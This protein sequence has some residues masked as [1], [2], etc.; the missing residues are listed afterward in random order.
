MPPFGARSGVFC[1]T[2]AICSDCASTPNSLGTPVGTD[3]YHSCA[4]RAGQD[5]L[6]S[7]LAEFSVSPIVT[8]QGCVPAIVWIVV[9]CLGEYQ[10]L[11]TVEESVSRKRVFATKGLR[12]HWLN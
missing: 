2:S 6:L 10:V 12:C 8:A 7:W 9:S 1:A 3:G 5:L 11:A 4:I